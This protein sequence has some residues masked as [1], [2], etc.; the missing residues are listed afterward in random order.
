MFKNLSIGKKLF[1]I[2]MISTS[3]A[4]FIATLLYAA[5]ERLA[6]RST[7]EYIVASQAS[8]VGRNATAA[9]TF[10]DQ[11]EAV[12]ILSAFENQIHITEARLYDSN[13]ELFAAYRASPATVQDSATLQG[14]GFSS[15]NFIELTQPIWLDGDII[16]SV[17]VRADGQ[18]LVASLSSYSQVTI[19][20]MVGALLI[21]AILA[22]RIQRT[23]SEP[24]AQ[25]TGVIR[26]VSHSNYTVRAKKLSNDEMGEM[27]DGINHMLDQI[28]DRDRRLALYA[29]DLEQRVQVRTRELESLTR[30]FKHQALH[31][32]LTRLPNRAGFIENLQE[33][34]NE[35]E[36]ADT[37]FAVLFL[38]LD[39][40]KTVND[41]VGH[42]AG[43]QLLQEIA[44]RI[45]YF[46]GENDLV[47]RLGGDEFTFIFNNT[48]IDELINVCQLIL[49]SIEIPIFV[50]GNEA[51]VSGSIGVSIFPTDAT[52][53]DELMK[54]AD[55]A[56]Y[57]AK[58]D[59]R[60]RYHFF[61]NAVQEHVLQHLEL[62]QALRIAIENDQ[63]FVEYQPKFC[64]QSQQMCG[65]E[66][67]VRWQ[68][69]EHGILQPEKFI[70]LAE[71]CGLIN[72]LSVW[73]THKIF[74]QV[75]HW[76]QHHGWNQ[77]I[78]INISATQFDDAK[79]PHHIEHLLADYDLSG[80]LFDLELTESSILPNPERASSILH[81]I[82]ALGISISLDDFG[83]GHATLSHLRHLPLDVIKLDRS[84]V[85]NVIDDPQGAAITTTMIDL[86]HNLDCKVV[87]E[88]VENQATY[89][90][91]A[92]HNCD[93]VQGF[94]LSKP[95]SAEQFAEQFLVMNSGTD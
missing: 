20:V 34:I 15:D 40:F 59:G 10:L 7:L 52:S 67:L 14:L 50:G 58:A 80:E 77:R 68:H 93:Q 95:L 25:V 26:E 69:P 33:R 74:A 28:E 12:Q 24:I 17:F 3:A 83:V 44:K 51:R 29:K 76:Q 37:R 87:A 90:F 73:L 54:F 46:V 27:V 39:R 84:L 71:E 36:Y 21:A 89:D 8:I 57:K 42:Y 43:D 65:A 61:A 41:T 66:A 9:L 86:A 94:H 70:H 35:A 79:L 6:A 19:A 31:D 1:I 78:S 62:E 48:E 18:E 85:D 4:L 82:K 88:G 56:M 49:S 16:G 72:G 38:D 11:E 63:L 64:I 22:A 30:Q 47:A 32:E 13:D 81:T 5:V 55:A 92:E 2:M 91:L 75:K 53:S 60:G 45:Q 23:I